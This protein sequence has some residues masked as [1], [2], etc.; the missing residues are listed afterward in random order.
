[1]RN[2]WQNLGRCTGITKSGKRCANY[3]RKP[4]EQVHGDW[5]FPCTCWL[6]R[7]QEPSNHRLQPTQ[8]RAGYA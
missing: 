1:M 8:K 3:E 5:V 6:H 4:Y 7:D 2:F